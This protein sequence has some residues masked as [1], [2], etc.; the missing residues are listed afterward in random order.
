MPD[1]PDDEADSDGVEEAITTRIEELH[2]RVQR[3]L[4][5]F[6]PPENPPDEARAMEYLREGAGQAVALYAHARTGGR[7]YAFDPEEYERLEEAMNA[8]FGMYGACYGVDIEPNIPLRTAA[9]A[10]IDTNDITAVARTVTTIP[11]RENPT[12]HSR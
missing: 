12:E 5:Q 9:Q 4:E 10:L 11:P 1:R 6:E 3:D 7:M 8:W 2:S